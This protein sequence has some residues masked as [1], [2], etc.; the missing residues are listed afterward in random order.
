MARTW[1]A[2]GACALAVVLFAAA[3]ASPSRA[4]SLVNAGFEAPFDSLAPTATCPAIRG[5]VA[6]GWWDNS[7]WPGNTSAVVTMAADTTQPHGGA[8][9]QRITSGGGVMQL[10]QDVS[11]QT[12]RLYTAS[13]WMRASGAATVTVLLRQTDAPYSTF[14]IRTFALDAGWTRCSVQGFAPTGPGLF[15][16]RTDTP[17]TFWVDDA[18]LASQPF[19]FAPPGGVIPPQFFGMH[20]HRPDI[21]WP[22]VGHHVRTVRLWDSD[23][24]PGQ[25]GAQWASVHLAPGVF[26]WRAIDAHVAR[27]E[28][29]GADVIYTL[30]RCPQWASARPNEPSPYGPGQASEPAN[31]QTWRDWVTAIGTRYAGRI[32]YWEIWN[33]PND[34]S[35]FTGSPAT[36]VD[37]AR[38]AHTILK[39]IDPQNQIVSPSPYALD[40]LDTYLALGG[41]AWADVI[42]YHFYVIGLEPEVLSESYIPGAR[43]ILDSHGLSSKPLWDTEAGWYAP[44]ALP[45]DLAMAYVARSYLHNWAGGVSRFAWYAWD[46]EN[47]GIALSLPPAFDQPTP[48]AVAYGEISRWMVG[49]RMRAIGKDAQGTW[50]AELSRADSSRAYVVW[51]PAHTAAAPLAFAIPPAWGVQWRRDLLGAVAPLGGSTTPVDRVPVLLETQRVVGVDAP[52]PT[53]ETLALDSPNPTSGDVRLRFDLARA[54]RVRLDVFDAA[55]RHVA[56]LAD[57]VLPAGRHTRAWLVPTGRRSTPGAYFARLRTERG[58]SVVRVVIVPG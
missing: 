30:A 5:R 19:S 20:F 23:G 10:V 33:E 25:P 8:T 12:G 56:R 14:A 28:A 21:P 43:A 57:D 46:Q 53:G 40:Y 9:S 22:S 6:N 17:A 26:D 41:G 39:A 34:A 48:G 50:V 15:M 36:L 32:R 47:A 18:E 24:A 16:I 55:G 52:G 49:S 54:G 2:A 29:R 44:P 3:L 35:F 1:K 38:E 31:L 45:A 4:Q 27:A 7:C 37:L 58:E 13:V 51:H 11:L 42:G